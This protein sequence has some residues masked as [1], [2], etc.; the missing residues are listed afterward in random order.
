MVAFFQKSFIITIETLRILW[1]KKCLYKVSVPLHTYFKSVSL[2]YFIWALLILVDELIF[3]APQGRN[4]LKMKGYEI[5]WKL[6]I[7]NIKKPCYAINEIMN[8]EP[9]Y[10]CHLSDFWQ[11]IYLQFSFT[12]KIFLGW[13]KRKSNF[14]IKIWDFLIQFDRY[15]VILRKNRNFS[16]FNKCQ[17]CTMHN[18][19]RSR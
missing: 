4:T 14:N 8:F 12:V 13:P 15:F 3:F 5:Q 18:I 7:S 2:K 16:F 10:F 1:D 19:K 6:K 9:E 17:Y 11:K